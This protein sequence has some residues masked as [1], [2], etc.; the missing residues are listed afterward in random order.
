ML[1][2]SLFLAAF[3]TLFMLSC[4]SGSHFDQVTSPPLTNAGD[5]DI[6]SISS[7]APNMLWGLW[8]ISID[9]ES[10]EAEIVP[11]RGAMFTANVTQFLQ[12]PAA[13]TNLLSIQVL[14]SSDPSNGYFEVNAAVS[15]PFPGLPKYRGFDVRGIFISNGSMPF[16]TDPGALFTNTGESRVVNADGYTRWWNPTE[17]TSFN[18]I[19]GFTPG[20][21][22]P[23][24]Y[25]TATINPFKYYA[26]DLDST[27]PLNM[28][29]PA[30]RGTFPTVPGTHIREYDIQFD[31]TGGSPDFTF[32]Y[33]VD[34]SWEDPGDDAA[35]DYNIDD[36]PLSA[37]SAEAYSIS[38][39]DNGSTA[40]YE[41]DSSKGGSLNL[42]I[43]VY[44][45]QAPV[46]PS[47]V[48]GEL[49][50]LW[51]DS[52]VLGTFTDILP[53]ATILPD[54]PTSS[55]FEVSLSSLNLTKSGPEEIMIFAQASDSFGYEPQVNGG[56]NFDYPDAALGAYFLA[57]VNIADTSPSDLMVTSIN[58]DNAMSSEVLNGVEVGGAGF[59]AGAQVELRNPDWPAIEATN[60]NT[61]GSTLIT[62]DFDL[63]SAAEGYWDVVVINPDLEEASLDDGFLIDCADTYHT[64]NGGFL[65]N[66]E[67]WNYCQRG[68]VTILE[69]GQYAGQAVVKNRYISDSVYTGDYLRFDPNSPADVTGYKYFTVPGRKD[70]QT[71]YVTMTTQIDQNPVNADI[72][73]VNG[74]MFD[75]VQMVDE[76]GNWFEDITI[77]DPATEPGQVPIVGGMDFDAEGDLWMIV[78][79]KGI[80]DEVG[81][82]VWQ[83]RHYELQAS[84]PNYVEN[85]TD[86]LDITNDLIDPGLS[87]PYQEMWYVA[88]C[89]ISYTDDSLVVITGAIL[90]LGET[91]WAKYDL[92]TSPPTLD[93]T[94]DIL[95]AVVYTSNPHGITRIDIEYDHSDLSAENCR[96]TV[97]YQTW[98][99]SSVDV[100]MMRLDSELNV[101]AD[102]MILSGAGVWDNPHAFAVNT[103]TD[104]R[105][106]ISIDMDLSTPYNDFDYFDM[107]TGW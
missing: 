22:A 103:N 106:L 4:S 13:P 5:H 26:E 12:P 52:P 86:R 88:D 55:I 89:A 19:L 25:P 53:S 37:N 78:N 29:D 67:I 28:L 9:P 72:G 31:M 1:Y 81:D 59:Q 8:E 65:I 32:N 14:A 40:Y 93:F 102:E 51:L 43:K 105:N 73:V 36:Y 21:L 35:P 66:G 75:V 50:A 62:C 47:G 16:G 83:L 64:Y 30:T 94:D 68:D 79:A 7:A 100:H 54:G 92:S 60:E 48:A 97:M 20:K 87:A 84:S 23:P 104:N 27:E 57:T 71:A 98:N 44:D 70:T 91:W 63:D 58:P 42:L 61:S 74:R 49:A 77:T 107:P 3:I 76:D 69:T 17:F 2:R 34:A 41:N 6:N 46:N 99:G 95:P 11:V 101:L 80:P 18:T 90:G 96:L 38:V 45:W 24:V 39:A 33:A 15:H 10:L 85:L 82:P 56:S